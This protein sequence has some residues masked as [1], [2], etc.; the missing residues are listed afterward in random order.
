MNEDKKTLDE[1]KL[2]DV[3][4]GEL[5]GSARSGSCSDCACSGADCPY[6]NNL[7]ILLKKRSGEEKCYAFI[8]KM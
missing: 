1:N 6:I 5:M 8:P 7:N 2:E 4:G 3:S